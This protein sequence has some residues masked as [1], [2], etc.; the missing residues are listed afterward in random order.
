LDFNIDDEIIG[1][2]VRTLTELADRLGITEE[3][4]REA[5]ESSEAVN[6]LSLD[7]HLEGHA[8]LDAASLMDML[9]GQD[10]TLR[11]I[12]TFGDLRTALE[13][14]GP[15]EREVI[16]LRFFDE[17]SQAKI[18]IKLNISQ[19]HV[20]RLQQRALK[21]LREMLSD[22]VRVNSSQKR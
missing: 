6:L 3:E 12:E 18:A 21:R 15:R 20:S 9:G 19:M 2:P 11:E 4:V 17:M 1:T 22:D 13:L 14:L 7:T 5:M 8:M 10:K 16:A